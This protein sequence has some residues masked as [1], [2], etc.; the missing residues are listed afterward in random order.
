MGPE[1]LVP[2]AFFAS[3]AY[4]VNAVLL[5]RQKRMEL[6]NQRGGSSRNLDAR[7]ERMEV[8]IDAMAVEMERMAE[9]QRFTTKLLAGDRGDAVPPALRNPNEISAR[10]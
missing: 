4:V 6:E 5:H 7:L 2:V 10:R 3:A 1:V 9:A 8:A